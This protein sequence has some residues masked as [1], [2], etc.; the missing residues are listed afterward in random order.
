MLVAESKD[1]KLTT[2][3]DERAGGVGREEREGTAVRRRWRRARC[4]TA[5]PD[6]VPPYSG[7]DADRVGVPEEGRHASSYAVRTSRRTTRRAC[8]TSIA[9]SC[10]TRSSRWQDGDASQSA[11]EDAEAIQFADDE[12]T[13]RGDVTVGTFA[14][15]ATYTRIDVQVQVDEAA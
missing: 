3:V 13:L 15:D 2:I 11:L 14:E 6:D 8:W 10:R 4:P 12:Q 1:G 7:R 5:F 9:T